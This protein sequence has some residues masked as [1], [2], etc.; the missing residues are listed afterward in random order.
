MRLLIAPLI[1]AACGQPEAPPPLPEPPAQ[2]APETWFICDA[3]NMPVI[4][5]FERDGGT[6]RVAQYDKPNGALV[7]RTEYQL[8]AEEGAAGSV[9]LTLIQN[10]AEAGGVRRLNSGM[11]ETPVAAYTTPF[12]SVRLGEREAQCRW[13]PRTR[14][15]GVTGKRTV[16]LHE[17]GDGD[18]IYTTYDFADAATARR[19]E[20]S[21]NARTSTFSV[22]VRGGEEHVG[23][24]GESYAFHIGPITYS[25]MIERNGA[26]ALQVTGT[27]AP[28]AAEP[29]VALQRGVGAE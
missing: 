17:D 18:L 29:F 6:V 28:Q 15:M 11:M 20:L 1:L 9:Y 7:Q 21:E 19:V 3:L 22:E 24:D 2:A 23:A 16:V 27:P 14:V 4:L 26:G 10:G 25:V 8:G 13:L 12:T 5:V